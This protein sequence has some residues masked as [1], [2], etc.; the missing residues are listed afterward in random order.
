M[1][2][3]RAICYSCGRKV[4]FPLEEPLCKALGGWLAVCHLK[5]LQS[6]DHYNFCSFGCLQR[7]VDTQV[8]KIPEVF[9]KSLERK[10]DK[11]ING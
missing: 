9:L 10:N 8:P 4:E 5:G 2:I 6:V 11:Y 7:W 3:G 1:K